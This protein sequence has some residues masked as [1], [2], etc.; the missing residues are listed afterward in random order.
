MKV[1]VLQGKSITP[2]ISTQQLL[3]RYDQLKEYEDIEYKVICKDPNMSFDDYDRIL[4]DYDAL[5]GMWITSDVL[6]EQLFINHP[7][8]KYIATTSH[9]FE[10]FDKEMVNRYGVTITNT[11]YGDT[12]IAQYAMALLLEICH[13]VANQCHYTKVD[14]FNEPDAQFCVALQRHI[15]I[16]DKTVG[17]IGLGSIGYHFAKIAH[18]FGCKVIGYDLFKKDDPKYDFI[19]QVS[20]DELLNQADII[21]LHCPLT[22]STE[23]IINDESISK[24][25]DGVILINTARGKLIDEDALVRGLDS[26]KIYSVGLD[27]LVDERPTK[28]TKL[29]E[30]PNAIVTGHVA[31]LSDES[32]YRTV[33]LAIKNF[34]NYKN[35]QPTSVISK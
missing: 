33:D 26:G 35:G 6:V 4:E 7:K 2:T 1:L 9:G 21:S 20:L 11:I 25:K 13:H 18:G 12:T 10:Q 15:E 14:Y 30:H 24:M 16:T 31:W 23:N 28:P 17:V 32:R 27:V 29:I 22:D 34:I 5:I 3:D 19:E 8:L